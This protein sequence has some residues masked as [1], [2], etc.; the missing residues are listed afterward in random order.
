[1]SRLLVRIASQF[2]P[3]IDTVRLSLSC[4]EPQSDQVVLLDSLGAAPEIA[5][6]VAAQPPNDGVKVAGRFLFEWLTG[7]PQV[8]LE[9]LQATHGTGQARPILIDLRDGEAE[10]APWEALCSPSNRFLSLDPRWPVSR[11]VFSVGD[12]GGV[13]TFRT[14]LRIVLLLSC[15]GIPGTQEWR[16][17]W[18]ALS[19]GPVADF[20]VVVVVGEPALGAEINALGDRRITLVGVPNSFADLSK[21]VR[22]FGPHIVHAFCH[23]AADDPPYLELAT[24]TD[25]MAGEAQAP[26][27]V[28]GRQ[29]ND[30]SNPKEPAW[31][32]VLNCCEVGAAGAASHALARE[33][34]NEGPYS[35]AFAMREPVEQADA[36]TLSASLYPALLDA[37][38]RVIT[39]GGQPTE[40]DWAALTVQP[41]IRI[42][43]NRQ[44]GRTFSAASGASKQWT[45]PVLYQR[46]TLFIARLAGLNTIDAL[47]LD[48]YRNLLSDNAPGTQQ[49]A[50]LEARIT[51]L[52][53]R[54]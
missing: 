11:V 47:T 40:V 31:L 30:L 16:E 29:I 23:G 43:E 48:L 20:K 53:A 22:D 39:G 25:W 38:N 33:L 14:P 41:R 10:A 2:N 26:L 18:K 6:L 21:L 13:R 19:N 42:C 5:A 9:L 28:E 27:Q 3:D 52:E 50:D 51:E 34:V 45:L 37:V 44:A 46:P 54:A 7:H 15:L 36:T 8:Q 24:T 32:A 35:A 49:R 4:E 1:M 17:I 12:T